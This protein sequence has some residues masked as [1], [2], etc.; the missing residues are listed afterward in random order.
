[1]LHKRHLSAVCRRVPV[2][3][4]AIFARP[5]QPQVH[6]AVGTQN[7]SALDSTFRLWESVRLLHEQLRRAVQTP[8]I[9]PSGGVR[10]MCATVVLCV[11]TPTR[12]PP[13]R[14]C[15]QSDFPNGFYHSSKAAV[16][17]L[18]QLWGKGIE[19]DWKRTNHAPVDSKHVFRFENIYSKCNRNIKMS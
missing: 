1:M 2:V 11:R 13:A 18:V 16:K 6:S 10:A 5:D 17:H 15:K 4:A 8:A 14:C 9:R 12:S 3:S 7:V 19:T